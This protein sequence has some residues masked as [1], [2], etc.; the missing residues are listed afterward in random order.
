MTDTAGSSTDSILSDP[1]VMFRETD[2]PRVP[3][4]AQER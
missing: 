4:Q 1:F 3:A 2:G